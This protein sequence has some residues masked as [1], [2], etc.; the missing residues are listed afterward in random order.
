MILISA[1]S[2]A[3]PWTACIIDKT[4]FHR[5]I[6]VDRGLIGTGLLLLSIVFFQF[7]FIPFHRFPTTKLSSTLNLEQGI[8]TQGV[9]SPFKFLTGLIVA[10]ALLS[11]LHLAQL[12]LS[13]TLGAYG[14]GVGSLFHLTGLVEWILQGSFLQ[15]GFYDFHWKCLHGVGSRLFLT[16]PWLLELRPIHSSRSTFKVTVFPWTYTPGSL[17]A[18]PDFYLIGVG[19]LFFLTGL[20]AIQFI[21]HLTQWTVFDRSSIGRRLGSW[22][23]HNLLE[24][25]RYWKVH[26]GVGSRTLTGRAASGHNTAHWTLLSIPFFFNRSDHQ[27]RAFFWLILWSIVAADQGGLLLLFIH[28]PFLIERISHL[29]ESLTLDNCW[30]FCATLL[31]SSLKF[32][33]QLLLAFGALEWLFRCEKFFIWHHLSNSF[34]ISSTSYSLSAETED[35]TI[36]RS[37]PKSRHNSA[38]S[39]HCPR[40]WPWTLLY[41]TLILRGCWG[42]GCNSATGVTGVP[43]AQSNMAIFGTKQR[44]MQP[45][46]CDRTQMG[47]ETERTFHSKVAKRSLHRAHRRACLTGSAWYKG[48]HYSS[49]DFERMGCRP[50]PTPSCSDIPQHLRNDWHNCNRRHLRKGRLNIWQWNSGGLANA[51][52]DEVKAW[53]VMNCVDVGVILE[54]RLTFDAQWT[55]QHWNILHSGEGAHR[56]KGI[57]ILISKRLGNMAQLRWQFHDTGRLVH[58]RIPMNPRSMDLIACYQH[59]FQANRN[60]QSARDKWWTKLDQVLGGLPNRNSLVVLGDFNC[61]LSASPGVSGSSSFAW[62]NTQCTGTLH[63]DHARFLS[64]LRGH[65][66]ITLNTW[67]ST[68]G[69]TY[70]HH[71]QAS[72]I[73]FICVREMFADSDAKAVKYLWNSPFLN[74]TLVGHAPM[75]CS[76][77]RYWIPTDQTSNIQRVTMQQRQVSRQAFLDST[78]NWQQFVSN[79]QQLLE[80]RLTDVTLNV[81][82]TLQTLHQEILETFCTHFPPGK[83]DRPEPTWKP[84]LGTILNKWDHR[85]QLQRP[86]IV[87]ARNVFQCWYHASK[88]AQLKRH[89]RKLA[90]QI[91]KSQFSEVVDLAARAAQRHDTHKLFQLINRFA[92]KQPRKQ[93]QIRNSTGLMA[94][95]IESAAIINKFVSDT[96]S[97]PQ[98]MRLQ[99][100]QPPGVPFT[101]QQLEQALSRIPI[102]RAVAK[103]FAPGVVWRQ[104]AGTLAPLLHAQLQT[105]WGQ[106]PPAIPDCWR[107]GW[108][109]LI[110]KPGKPPYSPQNL[111][112]LALQEPVGKAVIGLL[113]H[114]A[115]QD[116][117]N[118]LVSFPIWSYMESRSTMEAIRRVSS[119]CMQV[120]TMVQHCRSTPHSRASNSNRR[121]FFGGI[122]LC[123]DLQRAFDQVNRVKLFS[124]LSELQIRSSIISLLASWHESTVYYTQMDDQDHPVAIGRGVR[125]GCKAAPGLWSLFTLL[126]MHDLLQ[127]ATLD[128]VQSHLTLHADD[129]HIGATFESLEEFSD[130]MHKLGL[131][132]AT[133]NSLDM[134]IN[135]SKSV[136]I[137]E[138]RGLQSRTLRSRFVRRDSAGESLKIEVPGQERMLI[139][140]HKS[141]KYLG[142]I[143]SYGNFEDCSLRHRLTLMHVGFRRLQRWLTGKHCLSTAQRLKLWKTCVYPIFCYGLLATGMTAHGI[144][145][146]MTQ[147]TIMLRKIIHD[148]AFLTHRT[149]ATAL[150]N[151]NISSPARLMH[152]STL[153]LLRTLQVRSNM[154]FEH[155]LAHQINW[156]HLP[157]LLQLFERLQATSSLESPHLQLEANWN[158][159]LFQC[160]LCDFCS[161]DVSAYRRHCTTAHAQPMLRTRFTNLFEH[162]VNG[163]PQCKT[164]HKVFTTWRMFAVHIERG[165]QEIVPGPPLGSADIGGPGTDL[166]SVHDTARTMQHP[167][168]AAAR[169]L[170]LI[171][172][173]ELHNLRSQPFGDQILHIVQERDWNKVATL[174]AACRYLASHCVICDF[175]FSRCQELHQH[176]R[177]QHPELW[178]F[179]PQ[180]AIQLTNLYSEDSPCP[181]CGSLFRT[182]S[183]STWSQIA[184]LLVNGAG[185][186]APDE[187]PLHEERQRCELCLQCFADPASLV[188]HLQAQHGLQGLSFNESRDSLDHTSACAH[189][190]QLFATKAGLKSHIVQGRCQYFNPQA[191]AETK[192]VEAQWAEACL[193]GKWV[194][195]LRPAATRMRLTVVCQA[196]GKGCGRSA[197]LALHLQSAHARL[198]RQSR[199]LTMV[200]TEVFAQQPCCCNPSLG[201]KR[202]QHI[203]MPLRQMAMCFHRLNKEPF[204]PNVI[205]EQV[206]HSVL[207]DQLSREDRYMLEQVLAHRQFE[208][209]WQDSGILRMLRAQCLFCGSRPLLAEMTLHLRQ[210]HPCGHPMF[211]FYMEQLVPHVHAL[212]PDDYQCQLCSLIF[213]LPSHLRPDE[214]LSDRVLLALSH[215]RGSCPVLIQISLLLGSLLNG[216]RLQSGCQHG[217]FRSDHISSD[218]GDLLRSGAAAA[219]SEPQ[220]D[221]QPKADKG[222]TQRRRKQPRLSRAHASAGQ[223]SREGTDPSQHHGSHADPTRP[224]T[225]RPPAHG[226]IHSFFESRS[227]RRAA[228]PDS[229]IGGL[230]SANG[231]P[232]TTTEAA[233]EAASGAHPAEGASDQCGQDRGE[234]GHGT[235]VSEVRQDGPDSGGQKFSIPPMGRPEATAGDRQKASNQCSE[236]VSALDGAA[237][238]DAG[239]GD[240]CALP[241]TEGIKPSGHQGDTLAPADQLEERQSLRPAVSALPQLNLDGSRGNAEAT[242]ADP[243][244]TGV[245]P[246]DT[247]GQRQGQ[248]QKQEQDQH[249]SQTG[250]LMMGSDTD[251]ALKLAKCFFGLQLQNDRNWCYANSCLYCMLWTLLSLDEPDIPKWGPHRVLLTDFL[252]RHAAVP[253]A[254][255]DHSWFRDILCNWGPSQGQK[256]SAEC[257]QHFLTWLRADAF[258]MSWERRLDTAEGIVSVDHSIASTPIHLTI[259]HHMHD[260]G[261]CTLNDLILTWSQEQSMRAALLGA[262]TCLCLAIDRYHQD[263][264]GNISRSMCSIGLETEVNMPVFVNHG[265]KYDFTGYIPV[266]GTAHMGSDQ[267]GHCKAVL[268]IQPTLISHTQPA[269]FLETEDGMT[270]QPIWRAPTWFAKH[271]TVIWLVRTDCLRLQVY[272]PPSQDTTL[273]E[274][275]E[276]AVPFHEDTMDT[277]PPAP[278]TALLTLL[279]AQDGAA[280]PE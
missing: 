133:L 76:I 153:G 226:S 139:P 160:A 229:G 265:L 245:D 118:H 24:Y 253:A 231:E 122:Q 129:I 175:Q 179:A 59:T 88:F 66:L 182:H 239:Q 214:S 237:R 169:G 257:A 48:R 74:Q 205:T 94:T 232:N 58:V 220:A 203:C 115:M 40:I 241:C 249:S 213:N 113:I 277:I 35:Q 51:T 192:E 197:D 73:D 170:R 148:H 246:A 9:G 53:L 86:R 218:D 43:F 75:L 163:L 114:L 132:F 41:I 1:C 276:A 259:T 255:A 26:S 173:A 93:I 125:Q 108:L 65:S 4:I 46:M 216:G 81:N 77:A 140:I 45:Q 70:V 266:A 166:G 30:T 208:A 244:T 67:S 20:F 117:Q 55:D 248:G 236:D 217:P 252:T 22:C 240:D 270:P 272:C 156:D 225:E 135:Q 95:P 280:N 111:R 3:C 165:C 164:C 84:A 120:R 91:R 109:F 72:R 124:R 171:T 222:T 11:G 82:S 262:P 100:D 261:T 13:W 137:L 103:P 16:G 8:W 49:Q 127:F 142:V 193:H 256:D 105:W 5:K 273:P 279:Q 155:D 186:E 37:G 38:R 204:A 180:K 157:A 19:S 7:A 181:C 274:V 123:L 141:T 194:D 121:G 2:F 223:T 228:P 146:A 215:L 268:K 152:E 195:I 85:R 250:G 68:L 128:W 29:R 147:M 158:T 184:V 199:R 206:L 79:A 198:W 191:S 243:I 32:T 97:G 162:A 224:R 42:E 275:S 185:V 110:P 187:P 130:F 90:R 71:D 188:Q 15:R 78:P 260:T 143:I 14:R 159:P 96:W 200:L 63:P 60:C 177:L 21:W 150:A 271:A 23:F 254:L 101:I 50:L 18:H 258:D 56:G 136:A 52:L 149:N 174:Q 189:C 69:P 176:F 210:E 183:C 212:N 269:A 25:N 251:L 151:Q 107:H 227:N 36:S 54:T 126:F 83:V 12:T 112:P 99:F 10:L 242:Y 221:S 57:M 98:L 119:H 47:P 87:T 39:R 264:A 168:D 27:Y 278:E 89:H 116:V 202:A 102:T 267:A 33:A 201:I 233:I 131:V 219:G 209:L 6:Q 44:G 61:S 234:Q 247:A 263:E 190:G 138:M 31:A 207:S 92:P 64:I 145:K 230:E 106:N 80:T 104:L 144:Q 196:C 154:L 17:S 34:L 235:A 211:M 172:A 167:S 62:R 161:E 28:W 178:E 134:H 238:D